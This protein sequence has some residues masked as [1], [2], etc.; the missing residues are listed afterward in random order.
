[1]VAGSSNG[2]RGFTNAHAVVPKLYLSAK[3]KMLLPEATAIYCRPFS[4]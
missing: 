3:V 4:M 2:R 1:M